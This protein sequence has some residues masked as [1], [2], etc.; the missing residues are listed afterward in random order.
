M[1][2][3]QILVTGATGAVGSALVPRLLDDPDNRLW[4]LLRAD[5][6]TQLAARLESLFAYWEVAPG[7][8]RR[9][10]IR[11]M[12]GDVTLADFGLEP[13]AQQVLTAEC[14]QIVHSAGIVRMNLPLD[15][16]RRSAVDAA[17]HLIQLA[18]RC[19]RLNKIEYV[20]T[21]GVGGR[22]NSVPETWIDQ[23]RSFHNTYEQ[24]KAE[25]EELIRDAV[26]AGLPLTVHR[27][28]M[29]VGDSQT[30][31]IIHYQVFYH[32]CEFL[33][34][35]RSFGLSPSFGDARL[36]I[37]PS[38]Y[39]ARVLAGSLT[40][41]ALAGRILHLCSGPLGSTPLI[42]LQDRVRDLFRAQGRGLSRRFTLPP[43]LFQG[44]L[45]LASRLMDEKTR[46]A[47]ATLPI[48]LDY[49]DS[50]QQ[51][52]NQETTLIL[53]QAGIST[54]AW[55]DYLDIVLLAYLDSKP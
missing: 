6:D 31:R 2:E 25:A 46:R 48:F 34:G 38:D 17:R 51:F 37:V 21:V 19:Q 20:S 12:R 24:A 52:E 4:L 55:R 1:P 33:S 35:G 7:D 49:L 26:E 50:K 27:P 53:G 18:Q 45:S 43:K 11:A 5:S 39:V 3:K 10:R 29:V 28:S 47:V 30:G 14:S 15:V 9:S 16:A 54:P 42:E 13:A 8:D 40:Q 36:D 41:P 32:L 22:L 23:P 44:V